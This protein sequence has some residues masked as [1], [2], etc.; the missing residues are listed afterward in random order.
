M[1]FSVK[2]PTKI[3]GKIYLPCVCYTVTKALSATIN[4]LAENGKAN[5][6]KEEVYF[7]SGKALKS[8]AERDAELKDQ[9]KAEKK[10]K[11]EASALESSETEGF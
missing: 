2:R 5:L 1:F 9:K 11:K 6:Y 10:A 8:K 4:A 7:Q 3:N